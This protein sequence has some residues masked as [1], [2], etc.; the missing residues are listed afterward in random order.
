MS[1]G[2]ACPFF[3]D[4]KSAG[5]YKVGMRHVFLSAMVLM[6]G[7]LAWG[8]ETRWKAAVASVRITP[9]KPIL[10]QGYGSRVHPS[11]GVVHDLYVKALAI[12]DGSGRVAVLVSSD[13]LGFPA[14]VANHI[15]Q[16]AEKQFGLRRDR[17]LLNST[18]THG[19]PA[20]AHPHQMMYGARGTPEQVCDVDDYTRE[21]EVKTVSAIEMALK[22]L[23][24]ARV[25]FGHTQADFAANRRQKTDKGMILGV[26]PEGP[27][28]RDVPLLVVE[29]QDDKLM[30]VVFG[31]ACHNTTG[32]GD[33]YE[34]HGDYAGFAQAELEKKHP[35]V[36]AMFVQ[37]CGGDANPN[38]RGTLDLTR[39][40]G[41]TLAAAVDGALK[42]D[43]R[44]IGGPLKS[45]YDT[46]PL[47]FAPPP[48]R[49]ALE[50]L[51]GDKD[52]F[53]R[54]QGQELLKVMERQGKLPE[55]WPY[56]IQV[57]QFGKDLTLIGLS[58]EV[59]VDY[60]LRLKKDLGADRTWV[61]GYCNDVSCYIPTARMLEEGGYEPELSMIYYVQPGPFA[62]VIE[63]G[64]IRKAH[65]LVE[66][67]KVK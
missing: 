65:Q 63:E 47:A 8:Q 3:R 13:I 45:V 56:P 5:W 58:G 60:G 27:V 39:Q 43:L 2:Q 61:L 57:W 29:S 7:S 53:R 15:A 51:L 31:Y 25:R 36:V 46:V 10:M 21:L 23:Q 55:Q 11:T 9:E 37:G 67:V 26:N 22:R 49:T 17:L 28:D 41:R 34:L 4:G 54:W 50:K 32:G 14:A 6:A 33:I 59:V 1:Q 18:H 40:H 52:V 24:P 35:G 62:P 42:G 16:E 12:D 48:D 20:L 44:P 66:Q 64:I 30:A 19:G 38:P